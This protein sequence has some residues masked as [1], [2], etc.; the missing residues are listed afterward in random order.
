MLGYSWLQLGKS[1]S[2]ARA[3]TRR[4][5][6]EEAFFFFNQSNKARGPML[7]KL[8]SR[9]PLSLRSLLRPR[10]SELLENARQAYGYGAGKVQLTSSS[11]QLNSS[12]LAYVGCRPKLTH[13]Y[14]LQL[15]ILQAA[16]AAPFESFSIVHLRMTDVSRAQL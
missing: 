1:G 3:L 9:R 7:L 5:D 16:A 6:F 10:N 2:I 8:F 13:Y 15:I 4:Y 11:T 12:L 14:V